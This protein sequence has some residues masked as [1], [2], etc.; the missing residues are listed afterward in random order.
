MLVNH[1]E[2]ITSLQ[3]LSNNA[4]SIGQLIKERILVAKDT[5]MIYTCQNPDLIET[6]R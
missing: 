2:E 5:G 6:V 1:L 4:K 3:T